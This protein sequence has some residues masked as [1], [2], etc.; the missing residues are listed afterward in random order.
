M[1]RN[2]EAESEFTAARTGMVPYFSDYQID[3]FVALDRLRAASYSHQWGKVIAG[4]PDLPGDMKQPNAFFAGRAYT[5][6][7]IYPQAEADL[8]TGLRWVIPGNLV[9]S[10]SD[11]FLSELSQFYLG[12]VLEEDG[13]RAD[14]RKSYQLFLSHFEHST[15]RVPQITE[16][17]SALKRLVAPGTK[18][19]G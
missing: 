4:W 8:R 18:S 10:Y 19:K 5:E 3:K 14:A 13:K 12:K 9:F 6:L 1:N 16:A 7:A 15:S 17:R 11:F 2:A